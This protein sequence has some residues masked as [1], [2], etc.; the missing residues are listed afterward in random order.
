MSTDYKSEQQRLIWQISVQVTSVE[1]NKTAIMD[2]A[3][4]KKANEKNI[5]LAERDL[6]SQDEMRGT[7]PLERQK[8]RSF[9]ASQ[10][11]MIEKQRLDNLEFIDRISRHLD[12]I[13]ASILAAEEY[14]KNLSSLSEAHGSLSPDEYLSYVQ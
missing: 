13:R 5:E 6:E 7:S 4:K 11:A 8:I 12:N 3:N 1:Q 10:R 2:L 14:R 9:I